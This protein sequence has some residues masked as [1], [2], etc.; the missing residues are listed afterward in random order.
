MQS[1]IKRQR[2][3]IDGGVCFMSRR[4]RFSPLPHSPSRFETKRQK[5]HHK[6]SFYS[7]KSFLSTYMHKKRKKE[8]KKTPRQFARGAAT[9]ARKGEPEIEKLFPPPPKFFLIRN[10]S[11]LSLRCKKKVKESLFLFH[12]PSLALFRLRNKWKLLFLFL[13]T[14]LLSF[15][16]FV[17]EVFIFFFFFFL[18]KFSL[19]LRKNFLILFLIYASQ[20]LDFGKILYR[21][22]HLSLVSLRQKA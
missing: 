14:A 2:K 8:G 17:D 22:R 4:A 3:F 5:P 15:P 21:R 20:A 16:S 10:F 1:H 12:F 7:W 9:G 18:S 11:L 13:H 6:I 19:K